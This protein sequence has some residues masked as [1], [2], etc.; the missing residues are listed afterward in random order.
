MALLLARQILLPTHLVIHLHQLPMEPASWRT[1]QTLTRGGGFFS[2]EMFGRFLVED[3]KLKQHQPFKVGHFCTSHQP[4][5]LRWE[6]STHAVLLRKLEIALT[7]HQAETPTKV[8][9]SLARA[10][11]PVP[12]STILRVMLERGISSPLDIL[13][14]IIL[15]MVKTEIGTC[16]ASNLL[17]QICGLFS[18][19]KSN[20]PKVV[21]PDTLLF[22]L[23]LDACVRHKFCLKGLQVVE[24]MSQTGVVADVHTINIIA[25][26][27]EMNGQRDELKKFKYYIDRVSTAFVFHYQHFYDNLLKLH[28]KFDD[29]DAATELVLDIHRIQVPLSNQYP[30]GNL[31]KPYFVPIGSHNLRFGMKLQIMPELLQ[32]DSILK[33]DHKQELILRKNGKLF[34]SDK[35]L[36][37]LI[38]GLRRQGKIIE[39][40]KLLHVMCKDYHKQRAYSLC[41]DVIDAC[42]HVGWLE[43]AHDILEDMETFEASLDS[44]TYMALLKAY[45]SKQ[46]MKEAEVLLRQ[47]RK[48]GLFSNGSD[49]MV[50][51]TCLSKAAGEE[52][53][54]SSSSKSDLA[55]HLLR[56]MDEQ[57]PIPPVIYELNS[58]IYFFCKA[59]MLSDALRTYRRM[60]KMKIQ[61][62]TQTFA[63]LIFA[64]SSM[65]KYR[66]ITILWG[67]MKKNMKSGNLEMSR[68]LY[69]LLLL[70]FIRGGYFE[71][72]MEVI[73]QMKEQGM[74]TDKGMYRAEFLKLHKHLYKSL[75]ASE[76]RTEVQKY[77]LEHVKTFRRWVGID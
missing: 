52:S 61:F 39:L 62:T 46:M 56:E 29:I 15:H 24:L 68:D 63:Y 51:S 70:S 35:G 38:N 30:V 71:R 11:M 48:S 57:M 73:D 5:R 4:E 9:L 13:L 59:Q 17:V 32:K 20:R 60:Q 67:D 37:K 41:S 72:V 7:N 55:D 44:N 49:E 40:S 43:A 16:L 65:G 74:Y 54:L 53:L 22:N 27:Y 8:V 64:Y 47:M 21:R 42:I 12:A 25:Q 18:Q 31:Q 34:V 45:Y 69:E 19:E 23:V 76:A 6:A 58:S 3:V 75:K 14:L 28:F 10:Q 66:E 50:A 33:M 77:R 1:Y 26:I 2:V 36:A